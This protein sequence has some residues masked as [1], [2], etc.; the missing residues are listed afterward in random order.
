M[1]AYCFVEAER[2]LAALSAAGGQPSICAAA[3]V[4]IIVSLPGDER[5]IVLHSVVSKSI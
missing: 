4:V 2:S 5:H 1:I 3:S